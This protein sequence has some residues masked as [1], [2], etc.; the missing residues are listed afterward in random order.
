[1]AISCMALNLVHS[2]GFV[3]D[4]IPRGDLGR[5]GMQQPP[6]L[7]AATTLVLVVGAAWETLS[8]LPRHDDRSAPPT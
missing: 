4:I 6:T 7:S 3:N 8:L 1:M 2:L 5:Y